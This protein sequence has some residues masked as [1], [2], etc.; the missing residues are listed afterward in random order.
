MPTP[1]AATRA[2][3]P[4]VTSGPMKASA[5]THTPRPIVIRLFDAAR[6]AITDTDVAKQLHEGGIEV[7]VSASPEEF[8]QFMKSETEL[9]TKIIR[10]IGLVGQ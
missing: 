7:S 2:L 5:H 8:A 3:S 4:I 10:E 9:Y 1:R 6:K